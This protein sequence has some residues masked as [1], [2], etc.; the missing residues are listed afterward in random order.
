MRRYAR[1]L[2]TSFSALVFAMLPLV[3]CESDDDSGSGGGGS[4]EGGGGYYG[5]GSSGSGSSSGGGSGGSSGGGSGGSSGGGSGSSSGGGSGS[6]SGGGSGSSSGGGSGSSSGGGSGSS[7]SG[8]RCTAHKDR[9]CSGDDVYWYDSCGRRET[10]AESCDFGCDDA[11]CQ[12]RPLPDLVV[13]DGGCERCTG[14][15]RAG[16]ETGGW[17]VAIANTGSV[18]VLN[19]NFQVRL[20]PEA[21][22]AAACGGSGQYVA[23]PVH[24]TTLSGDCQRLGAGKRCTLNLAGMTMPAL[25]P[26]RYKWQ[27]KADYDNDLAES[28]ET[29]NVKCM[30]QFVTYEAATVDLALGAWECD[31]CAGSADPGD[32]T[33]AWSIQV[34]NVGTVDVRRANYEIRLVP[35]EDVSNACAGRGAYSYYSVYAETLDGDCAVLRGGETCVSSLNWVTVPRIPAGRYAWMIKTDYDDDLTE[36]SESNNFRCASPWLS[37]R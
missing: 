13:A 18:D 1:F 11:R 31:G 15:L 35:E 17:M 36:A 24:T 25:S 4:G 6:S 5:G 28:S 30:G 9:R 16:Q 20:V 21:H 34:A 22:A 27:I 19:A 32:R 33:G 12:S 3:A 29:N 2:V 37:V 23:H 10:V 8:S 14:T 26:G 7:A